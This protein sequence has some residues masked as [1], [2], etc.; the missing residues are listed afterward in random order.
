M[1]NLCVLE[2]QDFAY[3]DFPHEGPATTMHMVKA[4]ERQGGDPKGWL[5]IWCRSRGIAD[6]DRVKH[7]LRCLVEAFWLGGT[8]DQLNL[9]VLSSFETLSRRIAAIV[10]AYSQGP[11]SSPDWSS[12]RLITGY[13][14]PEDIVMP[15]LKTWVARRGKEEADLYQAR[16]R[17]KELRRGTQAS[18]EAAD[19]VADGSLPGGAKPKPKAKGGGRRLEAPKDS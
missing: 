1:E 12:A 18:D 5:E 2:C 19:S 4:M 7:E 9:P 15:Q 3:A 17:V 6:S 11:S 14:G 10:E 8:F 16:S 13:K